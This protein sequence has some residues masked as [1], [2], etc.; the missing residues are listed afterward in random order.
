VEKK[1]IEIIV[2]VGLVFIFLLI[3]LMPKKKTKVQKASYEVQEIQ[4]VEN[5]LESINLIKSNKLDLSA[6]E[7]I[8]NLEVEGAAGRNPF[9]ILVQTNVIDQKEDVEEEYEEEMRPF[10]TVTIQGVVYAQ[11]QPSDSVA[12]IDDDELKIGDFIEGWEI[13]LIQ[14]K[15]VVFKQGGV[16]R[17]VNLYDDE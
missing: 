3:I 15:R 1:K 14:E 8:E 6:V 10:P 5:V 2:A 9:D 16:T 12:V 13:V 7:E 11:D 17:E 4:G